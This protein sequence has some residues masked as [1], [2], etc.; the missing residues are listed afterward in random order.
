M[1]KL[2]GVA[3]HRYAR[4]LNSAH[5]W[6]GHLWQERF[7]SCVLDEAHLIAA[8]RYIELNPVRAG[9]CERPDE[10]LWSS[11]H[12]HLHAKPDDLVNTAPMRERISDWPGY[13]A[14]DYTSEIFDALR[15]HTR[16]GRPVGNSRFIE[17]LEE[18]TGKQ[19][20]RRK[21]GPKA[22]S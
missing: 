13:L 6:C 3:H 5:G 16:T 10:W 18:V 7:Y 17:T 9:L 4:R 20:Q 14:E 21:P 22:Q 19:L 2:F 15:E 11:I 8:V 1:A 12:A